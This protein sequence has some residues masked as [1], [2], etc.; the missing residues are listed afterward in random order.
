MRISQRAVDVL[1]RLE[2]DRWR[3]F[4]I[5]RNTAE[6]LALLARLGH[7]QRV[8]EVG[9]ANGY[10]A[11]V[12]GLAVRGHGGSVTTI[13]RDGELAL[14]ARKN[15]SDAGLQD[16]VTVV[17]GSGFKI[18]RDLPGP[19]DFAFLDAA[20]QEYGGY[21]ERLRPKFAPRA[22]LVADNCISHGR[23]LQSFRAAVEADPNIDQIILP[24]GTGLL[25]GIYE[26]NT[27]AAPGAA[28]SEVASLRDLVSAAAMRFDRL[29]ARSVMEAKEF[30][31]SPF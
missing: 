10:S 5:H 19:W 26:D 3:Y 28:R 16:I 23:E 20:K 7:A 8:V 17:P 31:F 25:V 30:R 15:I 22:L 18:L 4:N 29:F 24:V 2:A 1:G 11:I 12:L 6:M 21:F 9:T 13:E 14:E 27:V